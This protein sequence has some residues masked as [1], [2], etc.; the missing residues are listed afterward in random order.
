MEEVMAPGNHSSGEGSHRV[1]QGCDVPWLQVY[2]LGHR[3][4]SQS[5]LQVG[6][7]LYF[8]AGFAP[9][10][11]LSLDKSW[12]LYLPRL[13]FLKSQNSR[14]VPNLGGPASSA[15]WSAV[16]PARMLGCWTRSLAR[17]LGQVGPRA[18]LHNWM[19]SSDRPSAWEGRQEVLRKGPGLSA[20][21]CIWRHHRPSSQTPGAT[22]LPPCRGGPDV[23]L[24][25]WVRLRAR[26]FALQEL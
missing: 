15:P 18:E 21:P 7:T 26:P 3:L 20:A 1:W 8:P 25:S 17:F 16:H 10:L 13:H 5:S 22:V 14:Y 6:P 19:R 12:H 4:D 9:Q 2:R 23:I 11:W 24:Y